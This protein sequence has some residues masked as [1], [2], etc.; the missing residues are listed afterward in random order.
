MKGS[1]DRRL[2][3]GGCWTRSRANLAYSCFPGVREL[4]PALDAE[5][6]HA[7]DHNRLRSSPPCGTSGSTPRP[8]DDAFVARGR[9][10]A[11]ARS[12]PSSPPPAW[13]DGQPPVDGF[14]VAYFSAE[15]GVDE[16]LPLY[17][18]G[19]GVL[20]GDHLKSASELGVPLVAVG[21]LLPRGLLP[22]GARPDGRQR[23]ATR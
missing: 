23:S 1:R 21:L 8:P 6:W 17:S 2:S 16:S 19:L 4:F 11:R 22:P 9:G 20:A 15:F 10:G 12:R 18:G 14:L 5:L 7:V 3:C 13:W